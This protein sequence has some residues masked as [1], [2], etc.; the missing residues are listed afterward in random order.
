M[1]PPS[2][3]EIYRF[4][5]KCFPVGTHRY[6]VFVEAR[7][8]KCRGEKEQEMKT[9]HESYMNLVG[10]IILIVFVVESVSPMPLSFLSPFSFALV[11]T[12]NLMYFVSR[13]INDYFVERPECKF[14]KI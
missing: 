2:N 8:W 11:F 10:P 12:L 3:E 7:H 6:R 9:K 14:W 13:A 5:S 4:N 1:N